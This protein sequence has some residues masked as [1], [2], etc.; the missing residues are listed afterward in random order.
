MLLH[1]E[2]QV[3]FDLSIW[4]FYV[5]YKVCESFSFLDLFHNSIIQISI[6]CFT[7]IRFNIYNSGDI[8][9]YINDA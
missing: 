5:C 3:N 6:S 9:I 7:I 4:S 8:Y 1:L 2:I